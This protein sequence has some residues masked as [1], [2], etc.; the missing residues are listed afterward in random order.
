MNRVNRSLKDLTILYAE[1]DPDTLNLTAMVLE[2]YVGR[3]I[4]AKNGQE[5]WHLF[6]QHRI[7]AV[8][9]DILMPKLSG[10]DLVGLIRHS[11]QPNVPIII[12]SA[13]TEVKYLLEAINL[14]VDN[15]ILKPIEIYSLLKVLQR[16]ILPVVQAKEIEAQNLLIKAISTFVGGK[17]IE[18]VKFLIEHCD[19]D[20]VFHGSYEDIL[21]HL[22][23]SKPTI[24]KTF[25]QLMNAGIL[26]KVRNKVYRFHQDFLLENMQ[27]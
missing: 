4:L 11:T 15:Y 24:V 25:K 26:I 1:D 23:V 7:D 18:I 9:T 5:A 16:A 20:K 8:I 17:K 22:N 10:L 12:T 19:E 21:V 2:D 14:K 13:H 3:L 6:N 27:L